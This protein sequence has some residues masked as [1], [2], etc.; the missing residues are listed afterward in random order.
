MVS[1]VETPSIIGPQVVIETEII[2]NRIWQSVI[3]PDGVYCEVARWGV[4]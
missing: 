4:R 2:A 3:S 1:P